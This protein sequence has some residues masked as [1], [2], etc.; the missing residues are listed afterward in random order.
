MIDTFW[1]YFWCHVY[2][3]MMLGSTFRWAVVVLIILFA[4]ETWWRW[5][6]RTY[7]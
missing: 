2:D 3:F 4:I 6:E 5:A 1:Y 7:F